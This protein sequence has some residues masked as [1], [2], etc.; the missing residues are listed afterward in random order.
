MIK[1]PKTIVQKTVVNSVISIIVSFP[2]KLIHK[3]IFVLSHYLSAECKSIEAIPNM[4]S[5]D[6]NLR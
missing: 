6:E 5:S 1:F 2:F 4:N 3:V